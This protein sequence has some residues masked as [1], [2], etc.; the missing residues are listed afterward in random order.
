[1]KKRHR[2]QPFKK[3]S[4]QN[5]GSLAWLICFTMAQPVLAANDPGVEG[6]AGTET[7]TGNQSAG[8][9]PT[10]PNIGTLNIHDVPTNI[11]PVSGVS[12]VVLNG[13]GAANLNI[14]VGLTGPIVGIVTAGANAGGITSVTVGS[15]GV[16]GL[17]PFL[18]IPIPTNQNVPGGVVT[19]NSSAN[20]TTS[21]TK[22]FGILGQSS[23][24]GYPGSV[25]TTLANFNPAGFTF[26][27]SA[28]R[29]AAGSAGTVGTGST[30]PTAVTT[31]QVDPAGNTLPG[32][33]VPG[34]IKLNADGTYVFTPGAGFTALATGDSMTIRVDYSVL[35]HNPGNT[36]TQTNNGFLLIKVTK[37]GATT[38]TDSTIGS[39][40]NQYGSSPGVFPD[41][42]AYVGRL[43][44]VVSA[45]GAGNSVTVTNNGIINTTG[46]GAFGIYATSQ[47]G[48]G[49]DGRD[50]S[51]TESST[52]GGV[53]S[54]GGKV[55]VNANGS[56]TTTQDNTA[57]VVGWSVGGD[58]GTGGDSGYTR[59]SKAGGA[60][61]KSG[62]VIVTG[63]SIINTTGKQSSGILAVSQGGSG[64]TG[65]DG[66]TFNSADAGGSGGPGGLV[67][68]NGTWDITTTGDQA[69][70]IWA[71]SV[72][73]IAGGG[74][75][76]GWTG[77]SAGGGGQGTAGGSVV[78]V[79]GGTIHTGGNDAY[80][81]YAESIGGFGGNGGGGGGGSIFY[82]AGG[83]GASAGAGGDVSVTQSS[84]G[85]ITTTG[86]ASHGIFAQSV[87]GGGGS[88][89]GAGALVGLGGSGSSGGTGGNVVV[90]NAGVITVTGA[91]SRGIYAQSIGGGGGDG[92]NSGG[93]VAVGGK[94]SGTSNGGTVN[95][96]NTGTIKST[97]SAIF[98]Q[99]VGGGGGSGGSSV[100]WFSFGGA[101][102]GG[103]I[104]QTVMV[105]SKGN[106]TTTESNASA[107]FAQSLG[108]GGGNGGNSIAVGAVANVAIGGNGGAGNTGGI[109]KVGVDIDNGLI[110]PVTGIIKTTGNYSRGI[111]AQSVG[112]GGGNGGYAASLTLNTGASASVGLGGKGATGGAASE[113]DVYYGDSSSSITTGGLDAHGIF[114]QSVG[115]GGGSGGFAVSAAVGVGFT[116]AVGL[117]GDG[118]QG[119][120]GSTVNVGDASHQ[121]LGSITTTGEHSYGILAQSVGGGGGDGGFSVA[122][123]VSSGVGASLSFGG[124]GG[125]GGDAG[126]VNLYSASTVTT[127]L[128]D[129]HGI[130]A[131]SLGGGGGSGGFSVAGGVGGA[132]VNVSF[133]GKGASGGKADNVML[134]STGAQ[135]TTG[136]A[137]SYGIIAQSIGGGGGDGGFSVTAGISATAAVGFSMGGSAGAGSDAGTVTLTS[138]SNVTTTGADSHALFA[139]SVGGGGGSGG[140]SVA[141]SIAVDPTGG[142]A[143]AAVNA[144]VGG[145][146]GTG[147]IAGNVVLASTGTDLKTSLSHSYGIIAQSIG[148]GGGDGGFAVAGGISSGPAVSFA[149][150]GKGGSGGM[151]GTVDVD[152]SSNITTLGSDSIGLFAQSVG[153][154]GGSGGFAVAGSIS[155]GSAGLSAS[156]GGDGSTGGDGKKVTVG[157]NSAIT[158][159]ISTTGANSSGVIAQSV[160]GGGGNGGFSIAAGI[161]SEA[162]VNF[163]MGGTGGSAGAGGVVVLDSAASVGTL[164]INSH[165]LFAQSIGG[166]GGNGGFSI[167][168]G[169]SAESGSVGVSLGGNGAGGGKA[170]MV[171]LTSNGTLITT[172]NS[173]SDGIHA[174][175]I[176]GG[177]GDGGFSISGGISSSAALNFSLGGQGGAAGGSGEV[178]V[179]NS[180]TIGTG[181][182]NSAGIFA[183]SVGGGGGSGGFSITGGAS[184]ES[185]AAGASIGGF[186]SGGGDADHV[187]V[188][189]TGTKITTA[190]DGSDGIHAQ[191]IGGGGGD[192][193]FSIAG[194]LSSSTAFD[195][196]L[197]GFGGAAG[198]GRAVDVI[199]SSS[200][201][202]LGANSA[203]IFAQSVGGGGGN[204][205][206]SV[207]GSLS[208]EGSG[209]SAG[210]GGFGAGGGGAAKVDVNSTATVITT[211]GS[212]SDGIH[213]QSIGGGGGDGGFSVSAGL[214]SGAAV[215]LSVGGKGGVAGIGGEVVVTSSTSI[216]TTGPNSA[217]IFAQSVGGGGG[218]G[219]FSIAGSLSDEGAAISATVGGVGGNGGKGGVVTVTSTGDMIVTSNDHSDG[220]HAQSIGG[221]G[222][223]GGFSIGAAGSLAESTGASFSVGGFG[224]VAAEG[225][226]VTVTNSSDLYT[227]GQ[228]STGLFAQSVGGGGGTGGFSLSGALSAESSG[229]AF[230]LGG[231]GGAGGVGG[232]VIVGNTGDIQT[233]GMLDALT[234]KGSGKGSAGIIAQSIGGGGG[235]GGFSGAFTATLGQDEGNG[236][237]ISIGGFGAGGG[238]GGIVKLTNSGKILTTAD[239][240]NGLFAQSVGGGGGN[241][242]FSLAATLSTAQE[243]AAL[244]V[245]IGGFGAGGG[246]G[247]LV[248]I[249]NSNSITTAGDHSSAIVGQSIG[250]GGGDGGFSVDA[251]FTGG[252]ETKSAAVSVGGFGGVGG[253]GGN[254]T[255]T[256]TSALTTY[257]NDSTALF[258][259]SVGGGGGNGGFSIAGSFASPESKSLGVSIGGY[260]GAGGIGG[261]VTILGTGGANDIITQGNN[262]AGVFAQ[263]IGGGGGTGGFSAALAL[264]VGGD[265][266]DKP[267]TTIGVS[268]GGGGGD[269]NTGGNVKVGTAASRLTGDVHTWGNDSTG[270]FAQSV[271]GGGGVGGYS[272]TASVVLGAGQKGPNTNLALAVGG[273]GGIGNDGGN[274]SLYHTGDITTHGDGS[275]GIQA[276]SVGGGGGSGG[277]ARAFNLQLGPKPT[278][279]GPGGEPTQ[280]EKDAESNNKALAL[281][282]GGSGAGAGNGGIVIVD[283]KGDITTE[284]GDA[285]GIFAQ[286]IGGGGGNGGGAHLAFDELSG[287]RKYDR[288]KFS[289]NVKIV[290]GGSGGSSGGGQL[291]DVTNDGAIVT[292][293]AGSDGIFAQSIGGGGGVGGTGVQG[294]LGTLGIGGGTGTTGNGGA[295]NVTVKGSI[296]TWEVSS[297]GIFAQSVGGGGGRAG[298]VDRGLKNYA[299]IGIGVAYGQSSGTGGDGGTVTIN[300]TADIVTHG[301]ASAGIFAQ[302]VGGGGGQMGSLG[303]DQPVLNVLNFAGSVGGAGS[304]GIINLTQNAGIHTYGDASDGIWAQSAGGQ[305]SG[306]A[307]TMTL[308]GNILADGMESNGVFLQSIGMAGNDNLKVELTGG[309]IQGGKN[310]GSGVRFADGRDNVLLLDN[311]AAVQSIDGLDGASVTGGLANE[312][313]DNYGIVRDSVHL[314]AGTNRFVNRSTG[315]L[316]SGSIIDLGIGN[317]FQNTGTISTGGLGV[318]ETTDLIGNYVATGNTNWKFDLKPDFTSDLF[319]ISGTAN[320][321]S[322]INKV[323]LNELGIA[324]S[325]GTYTLI[326]AS[327]GLTGT[328]KFGSFTGGTM[329]VG[330]TFTLINS[331][332][333]EQLNLA[334]STGTFYWNG[335]ADNAWNGAFVDGVSNWTR[336]QAGDDYIFGT[337]GSLCDVIFSSTNAI[338]KDTVLGADFAVNSLTFADTGAVSINGANSLTVMGGGI[339]MN[340][341]AAQA[342]IDSDLILGASQTW[343]NNSGNFLRIMGDTVTGAGQDLTLTGT[344]D[345]GITAGIQTGTGS[346]T[347]NGTGA[348][349]LY[350]EST[351]SGGT[352]LNDGVL[353]AGDAKALGVGNVN[354]VGGALV[355]IND[356]TAAANTPLALHIGGTYKQ[357][358]PAE[359]DLRIIGVGLNDKLVIDGLT[360][361][362][363]TL[364]PDYSPLGYDPVPPAGSYT[365]TFTILHSTTGITGQFDAFVDVHYN[366]DH[367]LRWEPVY[368]S[369]DVFLE[370]QQ[371]P[372]TELPGLTS[373]QIS[374]ASA[375]NRAVGLPTMPV[376]T[377]YNEST[378]PA[379]TAH[380]GLATGI[381][382]LNLEPLAK[383]PHDYDLI[384]PDELTAVFDVG[385]SFTEVETGNIEHRLRDLREGNGSGF[386]ARDFNVQTIKVSANG[387]AAANA[388]INPKPGD[389]KEADMFTPGPDNRWGVFISGTAESLDI[390]SDGV[391]SGFEINTQGITLG[392]DYRP[393]DH[394]AFGV[395]GQFSNSEVNLFGDGSLSARGEKLGLYATLHKDGFYLNG[396]LDAGISDFKIRR[397]ALG[398]FAN[399]DTN[400]WQL[401]GMITAGYSASTGNLT[402]GPFASLLY[403][404]QALD[405]YTETGS[406][407]PLRIQNQDQS[408]LASR[409]GV[410]TSYQCRIGGV[411]FVPQISLA[412]QHE[413][414]RS[415]Y[416][417]ASNIAA[418]PGYGFSV[419]GPHVG[420][421]SLNLRAGLDIQFT[422]D[423]GAYLSY[424]TEIGRSNYNINSGT[425]GLHWAF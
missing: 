124:S 155:V 200:I 268:V 70:G 57:G 371:H 190:K 183:Q 135:V 322:Y 48:R 65:G 298:D 368:R 4:K 15:P 255:I 217:G 236:L 93:L 203:G 211:A 360:T 46:A 188:T 262:S 229:V 300:S 414:L 318:M 114:A 144:S 234:G 29:N 310:T 201:G 51:I 115:G 87:G 343:T 301:V 86:L 74:G 146:G 214:S 42:H 256:N 314:G 137:H 299:N 118:G 171:T 316:E 129:S 403:T 91:G 117:G 165:G 394:V 152:S 84:T 221:G 209:I 303:N 181:G 248:Q 122:A 22:A 232:E 18:G 147:G 11:S 44:G 275:Y 75:D 199:N 113:V 304:G 182:S 189:S 145:K 296:T 277:D 365:D 120:N 244:S 254:V 330:Y 337:P 131:Q 367:L 30:A 348:A 223:D 110:D 186:G 389:G 76:G 185:G 289:K 419:Q 378:G 158:G 94:G 43:L 251:S 281:S 132:A 164:G 332:V 312:T 196:S 384:A 95:V 179:L 54:D 321:G 305:G 274:V 89:G 398:G 388:L 226:T 396:I 291:V 12:G 142:S 417:L 20:I 265:E 293:G 97:N 334:V 128:A 72:G 184:A 335:G 161:S 317:Q 96:G 45:G 390:G 7:F 331:D 377:P 282:I 259:Q 237:A 192:G 278:P 382:F 328:F 9:V 340:S 69:H 399:G 162:S 39:Q 194:G 2:F 73:G 213:A 286:S 153:G 309:T 357:A 82:A 406:M 111:Q 207:V 424:G 418:A 395:F 407:L 163:S 385:R 344:G 410:E 381:N 105:G 198:E 224:G 320:L 311:L 156:V 172:N 10:L 127:T 327:S 90:N 416:D 324:N 16:P 402:Y 263:S 325:V 270:I 108:G 62:E 292:R 61:G 347:K 28:V 13:G 425:V 64:G 413:F 387:S 78:V 252:K 119:N 233:G 422:K 81:I 227:D 423:F 157:S 55:T 228:S 284:G 56:I 5:G 101:G 159:Q 269:G 103:G 370:W 241:G 220:I 59:N 361:L 400:G 280:A 257:G 306:K 326:T 66:S 205:G 24:T 415:T 313:I 31:T 235:N 102:G 240:S 6:P 379:L 168:G 376:P 60:G 109:V 258:A 302:S 339:T 50:A 245:S 166:G 250:G 333:Q 34:T 288:S 116:A 287:L 380:P 167:T 149:M 308:T 323:N 23:T 346:L 17:D 401:D 140:F 26:G 38:F 215:A 362:G 329:P 36:Q 421:D 98:A 35:G 238:D 271:G 404:R 342:T 174:Q 276:Q 25:A 355:T 353:E 191:S 409:I 175:S 134:S 225:D 386:S 1:M 297:N 294:A 88:G 231:F 197:G 283:N 107:I 420:Q 352:T 359:L 52:Q 68:V 383:L 41:L 341:G 92:G 393:N 363:G 136:G 150:G 373:N 141:A 180:S 243:K 193:G 130:F 345:I 295:V 133:G 279:T 222:G 242:G 247:K 272:L 176:G 349:I 374:T 100:G 219:G 49:G 67:N 411:T 408:S 14:N 154:G 354:L 216:G 40:L 273:A 212:H 83:N 148:G 369:N 138:S 85:S 195:F 372:F 125:V 104:G 143:A 139:Q 412:W 121:T 210:I 261:I 358:L 260:G 177:G 47:G 71:K 208:S 364:R 80:G 151:A 112:G 375:L 37:T 266:P 126:K 77:T 169:I 307:V 267:T 32:S 315:L 336:N 253:D 178:I 391:A 27:V 350:G 285:Y 264:G 123:T 204:G 290:V 397:A 187:K 3:A 19:I 405:A 206:F 8:I 356:L 173:H 338:N 239:D 392:M 249:D 170:E 63:D 351:Y 230:S 106:L 53:G 33:A 58:G 366:P 99:S 246:D 218:S 202:T 79:S 160:G 21:G 319:N